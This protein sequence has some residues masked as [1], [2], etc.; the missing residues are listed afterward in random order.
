M[1]LLFDIGGT[2]MRL[3]AS[4]SGK[5]FGEPTVIPTS[6]DYE[7]GLEKFCAA[8]KTITGGKHLVAIAG[9]LPGPYDAR[10]KS[11]IK[12]PH[13]PGWEGKSFAEDV[14]KRLG[15]PVF[16]ENDSAL[17]GLGEATAGAGKGFDIVAYLTVS[18]GVGGVRIVGGKIDE[19]SMGFEPGKEIIDPDQSLLPDAGGPTLEHY[20]GGR[21]LEKRVGKKPYE[22]TDKAFWERMAYFLALGL[23]N[24]LV[25]W[26]P[27]IVVLGGS[28]MKEIGIPL[29]EV[30]KQLKK[31]CTIYPTLPPIKKATLGDFGGLHGALA[32]LNQ[33][34]K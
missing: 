17:V 14:H 18:T 24:V 10:E 12:L 6:P 21:W 1:Y 32:Y 16:L 31:I 33:H 29:P 15:A 2:N 25:H 11:F 23:N 28:M 13:L 8:A 9:G 34:L 5:T 19:K 4:E 22:I 27:D 30:E 7:S 3:A 20:V 26:S